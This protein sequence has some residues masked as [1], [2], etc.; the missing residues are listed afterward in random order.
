MKQI[1]DK[2]THEFV[3]KYGIIQSV[4]DLKDERAIK[5]AETYNQL[6]SIS[7]LCPSYFFVLNN[8][9]IVKQS[10]ESKSGIEEIINSYWHL[11]TKEAKG[12]I[13]NS[14]SSIKKNYLIN[15]SLPVSLS[16]FNFL[17]ESAKNNLAYSIINYELTKSKM[18]IL[19]VCI[20][21]TRGVCKSESS[22][23]ELTYFDQ[24][25]FLQKRINVDFHNFIGEITEHLGESLI[26]R[27]SIIMDSF[28]PLFV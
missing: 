13:D 7:N 9:S 2:E 4:E 24:K 5:I 25:L 14:I 15:R 22:L 8:L 23:I 16:D 11:I 27:H 10:S 17:L 26:K 12:K 28:L 1:S 3:E 20:S 19:P 6:I 18:I 21:A